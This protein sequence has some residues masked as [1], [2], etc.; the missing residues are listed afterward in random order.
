[1][2]RTFTFPNKSPMK[3]IWSVF[4]SCLLLLSVLLFLGFGAY[5][6]AT[7]PLKLGA[8]ALG[9]CFLVTFLNVALPNG[10]IADTCVKVLNVCAGALFLA[11]MLLVLQHYFN[12]MHLA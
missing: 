10:R 9:L 2:Q 5:G 7:L 1:M 6:S 11:A 8:T 12:T 4:V 3:R